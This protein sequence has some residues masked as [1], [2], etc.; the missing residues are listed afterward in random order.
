MV[1]RV[2]VPVAGQSY[3]IIKGDTLWDI[4]TIVYGS[5]W[6]YTVI[7]DANK[8]NLKSNDPNLIYPGE[9]LWI[10]HAAKEDLPEDS[11]GPVDRVTKGTSA[12]PYEYKLVIDGTQL[13]VVAGSYI[14]TLDSPFN[15]WKA[16]VRYWKDS[17]I[18]EVIKPF[19]YKPAK[20]YLGD[21]YMG[22]TVLYITDL[23]W[24]SN[25]ST[26]V[27]TGFTRTVDIVDSVK[28]APFQAKNIT[29]ENWAKMLCEPFGV[30]VEYLAEDKDTK[31]K[32]AKI[33]K[34]EAVFENIL[35]YIRSRGLRV[36]CSTDGK[37]QIVGDPP[38]KMAVTSFTEGEGTTL[39]KGHIVFDGRKRFKK[40]VGYSTK[41][42]K[43]A[44][45]THVTDDLPCNRIHAI[46]ANNN[47][48][49]DIEEAVRRDARS[50]IDDAL[51]MVIPVRD[52]YNEQG[53]LYAPGQFVT[54]TSHLA[55]LN[56]PTNL[57]IKVVEFLTNGKE[58][59]CNLTVTPPAVYIKAKEIINL[60]NTP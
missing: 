12:N 28:E 19:Q 9:V 29:L 1:K 15:M 50:E 45:F 14:V 11:G 21:N 34:T 8:S 16:T 24:D 39:Q 20:V 35:K 53:T 10:P 2:I 52:W 3:T 38:M 60:W 55:Y 40:V 5:G 7:W 23:S 17:E 54:V 36:T 48:V 25:S 51:T 44:A 42:R 37:L 33:D 13:P 59:S 58:R 46:I 32:R 43:H 56:E 18:Y 27:L 30:E 49:A 41:P 26:S 22:D 47:D 6:K 31:I 57:I 4:A